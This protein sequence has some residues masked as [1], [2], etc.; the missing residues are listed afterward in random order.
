M[1]VGCASSHEL[2]GRYD[3]TLEQV[4]MGPAPEEGVAPY[5]P[6]DP[7]HGATDDGVYVQLDSFKL[8]HVTGQDGERLQVQRCDSGC[9]TYEEALET[10]PDEEGGGYLWEQFGVRQTDEGDCMPTHTEV[11]LTG[12]PTGVRFER[13]ELHGLERLQVSEEDCLRGRYTYDG[14]WVLHL[15]VEL[16]GDRR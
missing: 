5:D 2:E 3:V 9:K 11:T 10:I 15:M 13:V 7:L 6:A 4:W 8:R 14:P 12:T 1:L 16:E